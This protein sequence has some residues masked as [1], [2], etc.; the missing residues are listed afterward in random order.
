MYN[1]VNSNFELELS[2]IIPVFNVEVYIEECL[3]SIIGAEL[4]SMEIILINDGSTDNSGEIIREY[5]RRD[6]RI[7]VIEKENGGSSSAR[8]AGLKVAKGEFIF[9]IDSDDIL[10]P[11]ALVQALN[12]A[13]ATHSDIVICDYF[14]F[15]A[16]SE[17]KHRYD[18]AFLPEKLISDHDLIIKKLFYLEIDFAMGNKLYNHTYLK[19]IQARFREGI[20][21]EDFEFGFK[22]FYYARIISKEDVTL[23]GYRQ[24]QGSIMKT[25]SKKILDKKTVLYDIKSFLEDKGEM[26]ANME[27][28][29]FLFFKMYISIIFQ[30]FK[31]RGTFK[32]KKQILVPVFNDRYFYNEVIKKFSDLERLSLAERIFF[33]LLKWNII[34]LYTISIFNF[35]KKR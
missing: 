13:K 31:Y 17:K 5:S 25:V 32:E 1:Q 16:L 11:S 29:K 6:R 21:F 34:N 20:W 3:E 30:V 33:I 24:R 18:R 4:S 15:Y 2:I 10:Y 8:N 7:K 12:K 26:K 27:A 9:F 23:F 19:G 35:F 22:V 14:E 28:F